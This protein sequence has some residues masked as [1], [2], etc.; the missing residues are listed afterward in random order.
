M[1]PIDLDGLVMLHV[2]ACDDAHSHTTSTHPGVGHLLL[3][4]AH[5]AQL[6][7][8]LKLRAAPEEGR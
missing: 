1:A 5:Q 4:L 6:L 8:A 2:Q 7:G 3:E